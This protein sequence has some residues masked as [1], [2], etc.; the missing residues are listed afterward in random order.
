M[1][2]SCCNM[3]TKKGA[4]GDAEPKVPA[5]KTRALKETVK[6]EGQREPGTPV[7]ALSAPSSPGS[8][9]NKASLKQMLGWLNYR[10]DPEKNKSREFLADSQQA[11]EASFFLMLCCLIVDNLVLLCF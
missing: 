10:A 1:C 6:Q 9:H 11:L 3:G 8:I 7:E 4:S 5:K 2:C